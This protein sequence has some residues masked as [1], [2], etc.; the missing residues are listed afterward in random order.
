[1]RWLVYAAEHLRAQ[2]I[3]GHT[4]NKKLIAPLIKDKFSG[5]AGVRAT[6]DDRERLLLRWCSR[7]PA[8]PEIP[9]I[10]R[11]DAPQHPLSSRNTIK[12]MGKILIAALKATL[13][14]PGIARQRGGMRTRRIMAINDLE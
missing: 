1:V 8:H 12:G 3:S 14:L 6:K 2:D 4:D 11:N 10:E 7:R 9:G 13:R 5:H